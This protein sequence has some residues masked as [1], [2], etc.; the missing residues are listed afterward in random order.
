MAKHNGDWYFDGGWSSQ[1]DLEVVRIEP[2]H[3]L[4]TPEG[5]KQYHNMV[6]F[7]KS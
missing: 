2:V 7:K 5:H 6:T 1:K 4:T 3:S